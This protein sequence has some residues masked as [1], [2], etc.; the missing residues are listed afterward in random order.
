MTKLNAETT[1]IATLKMMAKDRLDRN[2]LIAAAGAVLLV[3]AGCSTSGFN[4]MSEDAG[5]GAPNAKAATL[6]YDFGDV[7]VPAELE[8]V[9]DATY[10]VESGAFKTGVLTLKG[11]L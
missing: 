1:M 11:P 7:L 5:S 6:Y 4:W 3:V 10:V 2:W 8:V 9:D